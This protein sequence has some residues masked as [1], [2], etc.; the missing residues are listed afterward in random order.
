MLLRLS[1]FGGL[2]RPIHLTAPSP[3]PIIK[4]RPGHL[5]INKYYTVSLEVQGKHFYSQFYLSY[6]VLQA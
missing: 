5:Y 1:W 6:L 2:P 3:K 4:I